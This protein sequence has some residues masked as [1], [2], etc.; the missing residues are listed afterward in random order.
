MK[1]P[2]QSRVLRWALIIGIIIVLNL[3]FNYTIS[4]FYP[5]P[6]SNDYYGAQTMEE[7]EAIG[8]DWEKYDAIEGEVRAP[9]TDGY[10]DAREAYDAVRKPY[11][12]N[13]FIALVI[14][15]V[16]SLFI[17]FGLAAYEAVAAGL[18]Y[19]GVLSLLI[20]S[21]RYWEN[22]DNYLRVIILAIALAAL[23]WIGLKKDN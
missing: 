15:G 9:K 21:M 6:D 22:A 7:C 1:T 2:T 16:A 23:I 11:E 14:L 20:A 5:A 12:R 8:G 18:S 4:L 3:F 10:C 13:V 19:G 17:G